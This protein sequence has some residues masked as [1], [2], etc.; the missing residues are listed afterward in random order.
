VAV[1][2]AMNDEEENTTPQNATL[3]IIELREKR[4]QSYQVQLQP[5][6]WSSPQVRLLA[7]TI[8]SKSVTTI[9]TFPITI[10][11]LYIMPT[12]LASAVIQAAEFAM[13]SE[14]IQA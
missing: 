13:F 5:K 1:R 12:F 4:V 2:K 8:G 9:W 14:A 11:E 10:L 3:T 6:Y 7:K